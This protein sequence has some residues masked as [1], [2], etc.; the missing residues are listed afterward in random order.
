MSIR[1]LL[2]SLVAMGAVVQLNVAHETAKQHDVK[3]D[4]DKIQG[5]WVVAEI[6]VNGK[7]EKDLSGMK[8]VF[9]GDKLRVIKSND[10]YTYSF[11]LDEQSKPKTINLTGVD[12]GTNDLTGSI[13]R[14]Q[15]D[16]L[17]IC[18][19]FESTKERLKEFTAPAGSK[20]VLLTLKLEKK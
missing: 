15:G 3:K 12:L 17:Q 9:A 13:Y 19:P 14:F 2:A 4:Q 8:F 7:S 18:H 10:P 20:T 5:T 16:T 6:V 11:K 1:L